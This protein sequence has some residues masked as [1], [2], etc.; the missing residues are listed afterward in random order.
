MCLSRKRLHLA[1]DDNIRVIRGYKPIAPPE[2]RLEESFAD[3]LCKAAS[4]MK[5]QCCAKGI[6]MR[7]AGTAVIL[8]HEIDIQND[9][10]LRQHHF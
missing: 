10:P 2:H 4:K 8:S 1:P 3:F 6:H 7:R 5:G 9:L